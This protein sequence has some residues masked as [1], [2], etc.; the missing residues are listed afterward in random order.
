MRRMRAHRT[1]GAV[2]IAS[3]MVLAACGDD[4]ETSDTAAP[5]TDAP[6][7]ETTAAAGTDTTAAAGTDTTAV[8]GDDPV[9]AL[10]QECLDNGARVNLI[11]LPDEWANY[12]GVLE[13]F[14]EK[15]PGVEYPVQNPNASS[16]EELDAIINLAG[17]D[18]MPDAIDVSPAKTVV[19][20]AHSNVL[21]DSQACS[22]RRRLSFKILKMNMLR[23]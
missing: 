11:A 5:A 9:A 22:T 8:A 2:L 16:Q 15:F 23:L 6:A 10:F 4:E 3:A 12:K 20:T 1:L 19:A 7:A 13:S 18:D 17:Q 14:G 21:L